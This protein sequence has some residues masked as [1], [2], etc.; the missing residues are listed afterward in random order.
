[1][2]II[3][4]GCPWRGDGSKSMPLWRCQDIANYIKAGDQRDSNVSK[5][6]GLVEETL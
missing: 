3:G 5:T 6:R 4:M 2:Q 1:M